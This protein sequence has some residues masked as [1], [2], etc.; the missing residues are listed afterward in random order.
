MFS[1]QEVLILICNSDLQCI[2]FLEKNEAPRPVTIRTNTL[3]TRRKDLGQ[4]LVNRGINL[5]FIKWS[6][7]GIQIFDSQVPIGRIF[8]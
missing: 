4:A 8:R 3:K 5:D 6:K 7:V 1:V 2:E